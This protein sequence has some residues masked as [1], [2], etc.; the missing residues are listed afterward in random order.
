MFDLPLVS[1]KRKTVQG[2]TYL[3]SIN[4]FSLRPQEVNFSLDIFGKVVLTV[5]T[6]KLY[7]AQQ[8]CAVN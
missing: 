6:I 8:F 3:L 2:A 5:L 4:N 1:V 7:I